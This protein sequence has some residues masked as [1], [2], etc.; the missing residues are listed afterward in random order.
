ME[1]Q[2]KIN[3]YKGGWHL[4]NYVIFTENPSNKEEILGVN[5]LFGLCFKL[6]KQEFYLLFKLSEIEKE[7][8]IL[9]KFI[10]Y[11]IIVDFNEYDFINSLNREKS[12]FSDTLT[13][14]I[15]PTMDCNFR[16]TYCFE[17]HRQGK[18]SLEVQN[19]I[20]K[21]LDKIIENRK[22]KKIKIIWFGGEPLLAI[23]IIESFSQKLINLSKEKK[24]NY[25]ASIITNG[26]L[27][28]QKMI[29]IFDKSKISHIQITLD[30]I[31]ETHNYTR[32]L[33]NNGPTF[34]KIINNLK[35]IKFKGLINIRHNVHK[36]NWQE[37]NNLQSLI[38]DIKKNTGN[39]LVY[40]FAEVT[41]N[42]N[43]LNEKNKLINIIPKFNYG[44]LSL[45]YDNDSD[46]LEFK[47]RYCGAQD[48]NFIVIDE[49]GN[50][51]KCEGDNLA[52][53]KMSFGTVK[54]WDPCNPILS[55]KRPKNIICY[56]NTLITLDDEECKNCFWL[57]ICAG[58][59]PNL[60]LLNKKSC[61]PYKNVPDEYILK[62][63]EKYYNKKKIYEAIN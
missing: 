3:I 55:A 37:I 56:I 25:K 21:L 33:I 63:F 20:L 53:D 44:K 2:N 32:H 35:T 5:L 18:M 39:N 22:I 29:E 15:C 8:P 19:D 62:V 27:L 43:I 40:Y 51:F 50:L 6:T 12:L 57:P 34:N 58:G 9:K 16:C 60:R 4:S 24:I 30:G 52:N 54:N 14:V 45:L 10:K 41:Y 38:N 17:S 47:K 23:D 42:E 48:L 13:V 26:Y 49:L 46:L 59:C 28:N 1:E 31:N 36:D 7:S 61:T 11:R